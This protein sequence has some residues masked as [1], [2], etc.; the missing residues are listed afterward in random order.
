MDE[1]TGCENGL[2]CGKTDIAE[3]FFGGVHKDSDS[4]ADQTHGRGFLKHG[5]RG[6]VLAGSSA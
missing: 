1:F 3:S 2:M 6:L 4:A 5:R